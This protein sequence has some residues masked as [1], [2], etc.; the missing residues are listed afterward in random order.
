MT[1]LLL[2]LTAGVAI[3]YAR[4]GSLVG[5]V[6]LPLR[7]NR[8]LVTALSLYVLGVFG[9]W[10]WEP[11][12]GV[13]SAL[14]WLTVALYAWVNRGIPGAALV[15]FGLAANGLVLLLNGAVPVSTEAAARAGADRIPVI[16]TS[17]R[18]PI[19]PDTRLPWL[20]K[21]I[22]VAFPPRPEVVSPG[23]VAMAAGLALV[24]S[25]AMARTTSRRA[26]GSDAPVEAADAGR[27]HETIDDAGS[28]AEPSRSAVS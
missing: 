2:S 4:G 28:G 9:G 25:Q 6:R 17:A 13:L 1:L 18:E 14:S 27:E 26:D 3:G 19:G 12:L 5:L 10:A 20:G 24:V 23:D 16:G 15:A 21:T 22:P 7:R 8:L 11:L